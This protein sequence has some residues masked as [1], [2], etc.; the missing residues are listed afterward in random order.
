MLGD[1][2]KLS[3]NSDTLKQN[4]TVY[5]FP[6]GTWCDIYHPEQKC[7]LS[8]GENVTMPSKAN[9]F[10]VHLREGYLVPH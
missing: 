6:A 2:L 9:D 1:A 5:Y 3:I 10:S 7:R 4:E 8:A